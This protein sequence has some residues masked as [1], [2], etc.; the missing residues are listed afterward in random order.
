MLENDLEIWWEFLSLVEAE[1]ELLTKYSDYE[2]KF[3]SHNPEILDNNGRI[4]KQ[5]DQTTCVSYTITITKDGVSESVTLSSI[6]KGLY[7]DR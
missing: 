3:K 2:I 6:V 7:V 5:P 4:V 1:Y